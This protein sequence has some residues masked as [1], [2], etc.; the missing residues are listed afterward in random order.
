MAEYAYLSIPDEELAPI[1]AKLP[2]VPPMTDIQAIREMPFIESTK[3]LWRAELPPDS[4][5]KVE[6]H[7]VP[8]DGGSIIVRVMIPQ[9]AGRKQCP[10]VLWIHGG[11]WV[12]GS[13]EHDELFLRRICVELQVVIFAVEYRLAPEYPFPTP[14]NDNYAALKWAVENATSFSASPKRGL[15][16]AGCSAGA[17]LSAALALRARDDPFF[18][19]SRVTGQL[20][21]IPAALHP[22]AIP[23]QYKDELLSMEQNKYAPSLTLQNLLIGAEMYK[24]PPH[25]P[26]FSVILAKSHKGLPPTYVQVCGMDPLRDDGLLYAKILNENGVKTKLDVYPGLPH[27]GHLFWPTA[28]ISRR[29]S[30]EFAAGLKWLLT[31]QNSS[32]QR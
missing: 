18:D 32:S 9:N 23:Q 20:L 15:V 13:I 5:Y 12:V 6:D 4:T 1:L 16:L 19:D 14:L 24:A 10:I 21:Q 29:F 25:H 26:E 28:A 27:G 7:S 22:A 17:N 2:P 31:Q 3:A 30:E 8:V 11:A